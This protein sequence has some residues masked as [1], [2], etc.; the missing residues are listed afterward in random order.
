MALALLVWAVISGLQGEFWSIFTWLTPNAA[1]VLAWI[2]A[3]ILGFGAIAYV[4][5]HWGD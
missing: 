4:V 3:I 5:D 1:M 2:V